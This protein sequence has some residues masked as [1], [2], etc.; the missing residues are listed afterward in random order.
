M[1]ELG[2]GGQVQEFVACGSSNSGGVENST[3]C[4]SAMTAQ[5]AQDRRAL[6]GVVAG[7]RLLFG[8]GRSGAAEPLAWESSNGAASG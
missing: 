7:R 4:A 5:I 8:D 6:V 2:V 1:D 3:E